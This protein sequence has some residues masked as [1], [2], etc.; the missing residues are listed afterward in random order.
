MY[1][2]HLA[3]A[4]SVYPQAPCLLDRILQTFSNSLL[5]IT[6]SLLL[7]AVIRWSHILSSSRRSSSVWA[8]CDYTK[9]IMLIQIEIYILSSGSIMIKN[10]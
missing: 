3:A 9:V 7:A 6:L 4:G 10:F 1:D 2:T 8:H 5:A